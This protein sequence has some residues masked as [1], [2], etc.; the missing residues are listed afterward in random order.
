MQSS[1]VKNKSCFEV[2]GNFVQMHEGFSDVNRLGAVDVPSWEGGSSLIISSPSCTKSC[3]FFLTL[4][5]RS[6][7]HRQDVLEVMLVFSLMESQCVF[8]SGTRGRP[9]FQG[10]GGQQGTELPEEV[11][12]FLSAHIH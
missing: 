9:L 12:P 7:Y 11:N 10:E 4:L 6:W 3:I 1:G 5:S 8:P 2:A